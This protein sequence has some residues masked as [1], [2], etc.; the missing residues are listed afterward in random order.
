MKLKKTRYPGVYT[1]ETGNDK[2]FYISYRLRREDGTCKQVQE[3]A[4]RQKR[5]GMTP[6]TASHIRSRRM[7]GKQL[8]NQARREKARAEKLKTQWTIGR[9]W[10]EY[11]HANPDRKE[12]GT[13]SL[14]CKYIDP[15]FGN[16]KPADILA[17]DIDRLKR[18]ELKDKSPQTVAHILGL[19]RRICRF[20]EARGLCPGPG[21]TI[22]LPRVSNEKTEDLTPEQLMMLLAVIDDHIK[23]RTS[24]RTGAYMMK[25]ALLTG[26]RRGEMFK[27]KWDAIDWHRKNITLKDA[28]SGRDEII[29]MSSYAERL[30]AE[31]RDHKIKSP[32]VFP[33]KNGAQLVDIKKQVNQIKKEAELPADFRA[34]HGLRHVFASQL[35]SHGVSLDIV[36]KLLTHKGRSVTNRYAHIRD[37]VLKEA[38][39]LAGKLL[40]ELV[41]ANVSAL[42]NIG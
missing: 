9:L 7:L 40:E 3:V 26:M 31:V 25:L 6:A 36:S 28:K 13:Q 18:R 5:D 42:K 16:K 17:L 12:K 14:F 35:V 37:D 41:P 22:Q 10:E 15:Y 33:G 1:Y 21:F 8:P 23:N 39:E 2:V 30:L 4:G 19:L 29:P 32:F 34:L 38:A 24:Q 27:L 11:Q 20:A